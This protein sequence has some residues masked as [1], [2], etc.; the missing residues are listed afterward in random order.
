MAVD[1]AKLEAFMGKMVGE[2]G[3]AMNASMIL[4]GDQLGLF[5][6][7]AGA[8]PMTAAALAKKTGCNERLLREWLNAQAAGGIVTMD[9]A[10]KPDATF[11][12][13][14]EQAMAFA[15]EG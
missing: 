15:E 2:M 8:G 7:M 11:T 5:K 12:L 3:A 14:D 4:L 9:S 10:A 1:P 13:P 6:A